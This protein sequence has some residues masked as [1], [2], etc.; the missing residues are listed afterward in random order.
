ML[1]SGSITMIEHIPHNSFSGMGRMDP[2]F[3]AANIS[4]MKKLLIVTKALAY[5]P[6]E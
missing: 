6:I 1:D 5:Y 4:P 2:S 3:A